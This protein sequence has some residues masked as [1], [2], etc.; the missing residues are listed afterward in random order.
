MYLTK[1]DT[2]MLKSLA[3]IF[4]LWLHLFNTKEYIGLFQPILMI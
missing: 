4:L 3:M 2:A 1:K